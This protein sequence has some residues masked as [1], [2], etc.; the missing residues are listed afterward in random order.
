MTNVVLP[1]QIGSFED[2]V[3]ECMQAIE[4]ASS[5]DVQAAVADFEIT[6]TLTELR[7]INAGTGT[8]A[9]VRNLICTLISDIKKQGQKRS[10]AS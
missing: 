10:Y 9:E 5:E 7:T 3:K 1:T 2:W 8:L 6:G 4:Y